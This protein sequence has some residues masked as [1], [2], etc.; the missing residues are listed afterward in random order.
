MT[1]NALVLPDQK[2]PLNAIAIRESSLGSY[3]ESINT[4]GTWI[5]TIQESLGLEKVTFTA[6]DGAYVAAGA[7]GV[8]ALIPLAMGAAPVL[9]LVVGSTLIGIASV[10]MSEP[11][12]TVKIGAGIAS[13]GALITHPSATAYAFK[14]AYSAGKETVKQTLTLAN[15]GI[16]VTT[17]TLG[18]A[19]SVAIAGGVYHQNKKKRKR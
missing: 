7:L 9:S 13:A 19:S 16:G 11:D 15:S 4:E 18:L 14:E 8:A 17:A 6:L 2:S 5:S 12:R 3:L 10:G 1:E